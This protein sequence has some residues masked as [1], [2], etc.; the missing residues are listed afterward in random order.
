MTRHLPSLL[1]LSAALIAVA[2]SW[3]FGVT[4]AQAQEAAYLQGIP[5]KAQDHLRDGLAAAL[6][7]VPKCDQVQLL[8]SG[9]CC[10]P[11]EISLG[12][13][14]A[15]IAPPTCAAV[16]ISS[17][18][19]C[20]ITRCAKYTRTIEKQEPAIG[21]DGK[22]IPDQMVTKQVDVACEPWAN[23]VRDLTCELD[24][25]DCKKEELTSGPAR[26]CGD[27]I[28][29]VPAPP[30]VDAAGKPVV[31]AP[32][33]QI[34]RCRPGTSSCELD[35][36]ECMGPELMSNKSDGAGPCKIGEFMDA[37]T[38]KCSAYKC[39]SHCTTDD[40]RCA[41]CGPDYLGSV[42]SFKK[43]V[44][45]DKRFFEAWFN[46]GMAYERLGRGKDALTAYESAAKIV[47]NDEREKLLQLSAQG[48]IARAWLA[49]ARRNH[50]AGEFDKAKELREKARAACESI[51]GVDP[52]NSMANVTLALYYLESGELQ[53]A[54]DFVR[55]ALRNNREDTIALNIR[56]LI[57][58]KNGRNE[59][60]RWILEEKVL[61][62]DPA[63][64]E[65]LANLG[66]AYVRLGDL[67]KAVVAFE[68]AVRLNPNSISARL[69]LGAIYLEYLNY[70]DANTQYEQALRLE[71]D[72][73]EALTGFALA[74]EGKREPKKAAELYER[75]L[76]KDPSRKAIMIRLA[77]LYNKTPFND[78]DRSLAYWQRYQKEENLPPADGVK[79]ERESVRAQ[80][81]AMVKPPKKGLADWN[82]KKAEL[83][84]KEVELTKLY[85]NVLAIQS[86]I[87][88][89]VQGREL[90]KQA[91]QP[92]AAP[93]EPTPPAAG[94]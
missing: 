74:L 90:E 76:A 5:A 38:G 72:N 87:D 84:K 59:I 3:T 75:V 92:G 34:I 82:A 78:G 49:E 56:G 30:Q 39:P 35:V 1:R 9:D 52:D 33:E 85:Q 79:I 66:L 27:W 25:Y 63:N 50:E 15:R 67:P 20:N 62:I 93:V 60:A 64:P 91:K 8:E 45:V 65:A 29:R 58:L 26:W 83:V 22:P 19:S 23:G 16:A 48:Y 21:D 51:R 47:P 77:L 54:E 61:A 4:T 28:K 7:K 24:T 17:P 55:Q 94:K 12:R 41:K 36:R 80:L 68:R 31:D 13:S 14:C 44:E 40:G 46:L 6:R 43:A 2:A 86:R 32:T 53:L 71:P 37:Q 42:D 11:G 81:A 18:A 73:L 10:P 89:I 88:E 70:R 57:N 69:N